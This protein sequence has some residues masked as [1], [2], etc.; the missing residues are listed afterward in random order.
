MSQAAQSADLQQ[1]V[2]VLNG[3]GPAV[4]TKLQKLGLESVEDLLFQLLFGKLP[5]SGKG[6]ERFFVARYLLPVKRRPAADDVC[7]K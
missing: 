6:G 2:S 4:Q 5:N 3:V 1:S 7:L